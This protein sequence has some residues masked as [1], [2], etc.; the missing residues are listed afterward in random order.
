MVAYIFHGLTTYQIVHFHRAV[1]THSVL[2]CSAVMFAGIFSAG[3]MGVVLWF[4]IPPPVRCLVEG[5]LPWA[6]RADIRADGGNGAR[7]DA[8]PRPLA[9][10]M[11]VAAAVAARRADWVDRLLAAGTAAW[12]TPRS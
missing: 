10:F 4:V 12:E 7:A 6:L 11:V 9:F 3:T 8:S 1:C 5:R 2:F